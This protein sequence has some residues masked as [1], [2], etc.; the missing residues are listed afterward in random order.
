MTTGSPTREPGRG[1]GL[2]RFLVMNPLSYTRGGRNV[3]IDPV[4]RRHAGQEVKTGVT[5]P[6]GLGYIAAVLLQA[7]H[8]VDMLDPLA[9]PILPEAVEARARQ[10][11]AVLMPYSFA[12]ADDTAQ[13]LQGLNSTL[14]ILVGPTAENAYESLLGT[15]IADAVLIG[16]PEDTIVELARLYPRLDQVRGLAFRAGTGEVRRTAARPLIDNLDRLPFPHRAYGNPHAYWDIPFFGRPTAWLLPTRG[17]PYDCIFCSQWQGYR[18]RVRYRSPENVVDEVEAIVNEL[19]IRCMNFSDDT[20]NLNAE[21]VQSICRL[22]LERSLRVRWMS[23][24][25]ADRVD[26]ETLRLMKRSGCVEIQY[27]I[28]SADNGILEFLQKGTTIEDQR[29]GIEITR[30][31]GVRFSVQTIIGSPMET[32]ETIR[33]T[34]RFI[35]ETKP[36]FASFNVLT[37]LPGSQLYEQLKDRLDDDRDLRTFDILHTEYAVGSMTAE[38][39]RRRIRRLYRW[40]YLSP[41]FAV[42]LLWEFCRRPANLYWGLSKGLPRQALYLYRSILSR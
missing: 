23:T 5:Y 7:G 19:G 14:R 3:M 42:R 6:V 10:A 40:Y 9:E 29:R 34:M 25:R 24:A 41:R 11:D 37:P 13:F 12:H 28:E 2:R 16:E 30:R 27:G 20:F 35:R 18:K 39:T 1:E 26:E 15:G 21:Y 31:V 32:E 33:K 22:L 36:M 38:E 8:S 17:C 4:I